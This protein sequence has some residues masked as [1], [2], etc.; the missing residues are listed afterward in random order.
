MRV[1]VEL[2]KEWIR[3]AV[4]AGLARFVDANVTIKDI[5]NEGDKK[6]VPFK[7]VEFA[8]SDAADLTKLFTMA[9]AGKGT[10]KDED[11]K[12]VPA[13]NPINTLLTYAYGLN[14]RSKVR[15]T[16]ESQFVDPEAGLKKVAN[17]LVKTGR[18]KSLEKALAAARAMQEDDSE[19]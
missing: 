19:E 17:L 10:T 11:G 18:F 12:E 15:I 16:Y 5:P 1:N 9:E 2:H 7:K 4:A 13:E 3:T 8:V 14:C 6:E